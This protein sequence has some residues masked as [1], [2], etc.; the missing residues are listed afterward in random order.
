MATWF[1]CRQRAG[2]LVKECR[3]QRPRFGPEDTDA[4]HNA[5]AELKRKQNGTLDRRQVDRLELRLA[6]IGRT[7]VMYTLTFDREHLPR[8]FKGV[9]RELQ[10]FF[11]RVQRWRER[12]GKPVT[13]DY[14]YCIEGLH[15][16]RRYHVHFI[17][18][19]YE[20]SP[21]EVRFLWRCGEVDTEYV[22]EQNRK[23]CLANNRAIEIDRGGFR[24]IAEYLNKERT[25]GWVIPIG[26]HPWSC[27]RT[28]TEKLP[29]A[30]KWK[31]ASGVITVPDD[32]VWVR[33]G[34]VENDWGAY[35]FASWIERENARA[36]N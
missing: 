30:E 26:R 25:D 1:C 27:S 19:Y 4:D 34:S 29:A 8:D 24:R 14:I 22:L 33:R 15:G 10:N 13:I 2:P 3:A 11:K 12:L 32:A 7:A 36:T 28:L 20:L 21:E 18:D 16:D 6:L 5:K 9:R 35:Y 23:V 31:D 17:A